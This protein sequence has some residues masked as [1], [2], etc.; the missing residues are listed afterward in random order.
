MKTGSL[1]SV[2]GSVICFAAPSFAQQKETVEQRISHQRDLLGNPKALGEFGVV[3]MKVDEAFN[4]NDASAVAALFTE[5]GV[6]AAPDGMFYGR[7]AIEKGLPKD[8]FQHWHTQNIVKTVDRVNADG[9]EVGARGTW[10]LNYQRNPF[11]TLR[12][13]DGTFS[14]VIVRE[15]GHLEDSQGYRERVHR[16]I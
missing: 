14:W 11:H 4:R 1:L 5:D 12:N 16:E 7:R 6:L 2:A 3:G 13:V 8:E 9:N 15:G 10:S